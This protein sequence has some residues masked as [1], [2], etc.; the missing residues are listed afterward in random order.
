MLIATAGF[1]DTG[2]DKI[3]EAEEK[4]DWVIEYALIRPSERVDVYHRL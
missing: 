4:V 2:A 3:S 1:L